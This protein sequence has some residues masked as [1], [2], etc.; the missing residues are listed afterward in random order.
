MNNLDLKDLVILD[1]LEYNELMERISKGNKKYYENEKLYKIYE[2]YYWN[3]IK[4]HN[5]YDLKNIQDYTLD[6]YY[7]RDIVVICLKDEIT[8]LEYI[9]KMIKQIKK[10]YDKENEKS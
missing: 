2:K 8:D 1:V 5:T 6:D 10:E 4:E 3:E 7:F 9:T